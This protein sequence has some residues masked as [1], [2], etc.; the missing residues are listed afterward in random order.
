MTEPHPHGEPPGACTGGLARL[1]ESRGEPEQPVLWLP[2]WRCRSAVPVRSV[3][4]LALLASHL[5]TGKFAGVERTRRGV[6][7]WSQTLCVK[8]EW[9]VEVHDGTSDEVAQRVFRGGTGDYPC[10]AVDPPLYPIEKWSS[11]GVAEVMWAWLHGGLPEG[12]ARTIRC[13]RDD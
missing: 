12:C 3:E 8:R 11:T 5:G 1:A 4:E 7:R 9:I 2:G 13:C 6:R 10:G